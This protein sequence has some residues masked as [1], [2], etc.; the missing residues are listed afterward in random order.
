MNDNDH[1]SK[2]VA[3][4]YVKSRGISDA[5]VLHLKFTATD[6]NIPKDEFIAIKKSVDDYFSDKVQA[7]VLT[8]SSPYKVDCMS[9]TSAFALG[10]DNG[11]CAL[12]CKSTNKSLY[13]NAIG[14]TPFNDYG[15]RPTMMLAGYDFSTVKL[16]IDRGVGADYSR[17][18]G[19]SYLLNTNDK[20]RNIRS[21]EYSRIA[22]D[23][24]S[25]IDVRLVNKNSIEFQSNILF[26]FTGSKKVVN[27]ERNDFL[28]GAIADHLT[29]FGGVLF[30]D[31]QM[32]ILDWIAAGVTGTY[33]TVSE[34]CNFK[35]K[36]PD[37]YV[38]MF[39]YL[40]GDTLIE[41]YWKSVEMPGQGLFVGEPL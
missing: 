40:N 25:V 29:S 4:Y 23:F 30:D 1:L 5:N 32:S 41:S 13:F 26:Y 14:N 22:E 37:P 20:S 18:K 36:F 10:F 9:I 16:L 24:N 15:I 21:K 11:Y 3:D 31:H 28:P 33:G 8:W 39:N 38:V 35:E 27:I 34:P 17:H 7:Y 2:M 6:D 12:G 19:V